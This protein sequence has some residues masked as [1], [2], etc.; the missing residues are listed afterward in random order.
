M[1]ITTAELLEAIAAEQRPP[2]QPKDTFTRVQ[3]QQAL[4]CGKDLALRHIHALLRAERIEATT[5]PLVDII[6]RTTPVPGY[7]L[8]PQKRRKAA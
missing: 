3:L 4:G 6:G 1:N 8:L 5:I 2:S 7:R